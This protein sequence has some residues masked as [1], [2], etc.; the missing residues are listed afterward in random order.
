M[1]QFIESKS[2]T[3]VTSQGGNGGLHQT[4]LKLR[5]KISSRTFKVLKPTLYNV[6]PI[7]NSTVLYTSK[8]AE[9][10]DLTSSALASIK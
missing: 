4:C 3:V 7:V 9:R 8:L 2:G 6:K 10:V 5:R 1:G